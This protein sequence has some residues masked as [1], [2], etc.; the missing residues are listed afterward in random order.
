MTEMPGNLPSLDELEDL[1]SA[2]RAVID[3]T[4]EARS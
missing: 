3:L 4:E 1:A 2:L